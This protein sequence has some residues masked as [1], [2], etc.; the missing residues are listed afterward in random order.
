MGIYG[1]YLNQPL[2]GN[3]ELLAA[4]RKKQLRRISAIRD[5]R[6]IL[7]FA[8]DLNKETNLISISYVDILPI[9]DQLSNLNGTRL[10]LIL[11]TPG[12]SGEIAEDIVRLLPQKVSRNLRHHPQGGQ[13]ALALSLPWLPMRSSWGPLLP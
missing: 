9:S 7:V 6:D 8:A 13:K 3:V 12:G 1:E 2:A 10:D 4:E 11:E 5:D